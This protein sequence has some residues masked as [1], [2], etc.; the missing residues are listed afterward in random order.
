MSTDIFIPT[1]AEPTN[2]NGA[3]YTT[4]M[5]EARVLTP[6]LFSVATSKTCTVETVPPDPETG[7]PEMYH[8][9][10]DQDLTPDERTLV[11]LIMQN[12]ANMDAVIAKA[13]AAL[14]DNTN[15]NANTLPQIINGANA[16]I[17]STVASSLPNDKQ[18]AQAV[19]TLANQVADL[20]N[21]NRALIKWALGLR[22]S[23]L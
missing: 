3:S 11:L 14:T 23:A 6:A 22:E 17:N 10:F 2:P 1:A 9:H 21:Q 15:W 12:D 8:V 20:D 5:D 16:I 19:K 13:K 4:W 7:A 18:L